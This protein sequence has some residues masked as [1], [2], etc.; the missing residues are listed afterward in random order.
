MQSKS[1]KDLKLTLG[2]ITKVY[3]DRAYRPRGQH[4]IINW[5][6]ARTPNWLEQAEREGS[7]IL[8]PIASVNVASN[9]L[10]CLQRLSR[11]GISTPSFTTDRATASRWIED[12]F[13]V[14]QRNELRA[15][16]GEG[17]VVVNTTGEAKTQG[18]ITPA[19]LYTKFINKDSEF[20]VHVFNGRILD[21][22]QKKRRHGA[23]DLEEY[24]KYVC[25]TEAGWNFCRNDIDVPES[26]TD[27]A[28]QAVSTLGLDFAAVDVITLAGVAY[29]LEVNTAPGIEG[30]TLF[31]YTNSFRAIMGSEPLTRE[32]FDTL[33]EEQG[34]L[35]TT[36]ETAGTTEEETTTD[37]ADV[38]ETDEDTVTVRLSRRAYNEF[39]RIFGRAA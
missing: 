32:Q 27:I 23:R 26:V 13:T 2:G 39:Q 17:I 12:G 28:V 1:A 31:N 37:V 14:I 11:E 18:Q 7:R 33:C 36:Q 25:S 16:S 19:P 21:V 8:N 4:V 9:K 29:V 30:T 6:S 35:T 20:R 24:N 34:V 15:N 3:A 5:G 22:V 10:S 38:A